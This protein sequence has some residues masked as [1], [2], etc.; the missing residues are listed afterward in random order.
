[1]DTEADKV[2]N[3]ILALSLQLHNSLSVQHHICVP[4]VLRAFLIE[5]GCLLQLWLKAN[6]K[7]VY[8]SV[9]EVALFVWCGRLA[10]TLNT[11]CACLE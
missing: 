3:Q 8:L 6:E 1:M 9:T 2:C 4:K 11:N 10:E 7:C 5:Q